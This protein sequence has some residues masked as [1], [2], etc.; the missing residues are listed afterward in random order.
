MKRNPNFLLR[1]VA[2]KQVVVPVGMAS[3]EF[4][5]MINLNAVGAYLWQQLETEQTVDTL[6]AALTERYEVAAEIA[7]ADVEAFVESL[8]KVGAIVA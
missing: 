8:T 6:T 2:G 3:M 7:K 4:A 5:G 1:E